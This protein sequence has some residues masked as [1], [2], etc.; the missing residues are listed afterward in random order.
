MKNKSIVLPT[1]VKITIKKNRVQV[2][3]PGIENR[4]ETF[5]ELMQLCR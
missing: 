1:G 2:Q 4:S 3:M 5:K